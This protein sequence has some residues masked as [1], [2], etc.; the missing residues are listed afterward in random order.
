MSR[1][2][3]HPFVGK[4]CAIT[5]MAQNNPTYPSTADMGTT[6]LVPLYSMPPAPETGAP[7]IGETTRTAPR[8]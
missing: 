2:P 3:N 4:R 8:A 5:W 6:R 7:E 1:V